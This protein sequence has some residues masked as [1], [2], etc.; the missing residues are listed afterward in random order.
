MTD[1]ADF[2]YTRKVDFETLAALPA[3]ERFVQRLLTRDDG[4][5]AC[6]IAYVRTPPGSGSPHGL[7]THN[8]D[9][10]F[11]VLG[12]TMTVEIAGATS[13]VEAGSIV[14]FPKSTPHRNWNATDRET[15]HLAIIAPAPDPDLP[16]AQRV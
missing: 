10:V 11:Y 2:Q 5:D 6:Q 1:Q 14:V 13:E 4:G 12:G 7:H 15:I 3:D 16:F 8:V 9:Q